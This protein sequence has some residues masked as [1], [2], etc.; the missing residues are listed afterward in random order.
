MK[1]PLN[2]MLQLLVIELRDWPEDCGEYASWDPSGGPFDFG[3]VVFTAD[4]PKVM[5][6]SIAIHGVWSLSEVPHDSKTAIVTRSQWILARQ[7]AVVKPKDEWAAQQSEKY[8]AYWRA[9]PAHWTHLDT[10]RINEL[11][12]VEDDSGAIL[13]A[14]K[15]LLLP[16]V[17]TGDKG[18]LKDV[19]EAASTLQCYINK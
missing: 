10:Y 8:P 16:G 3:A 19:Q 2:A 12:P 17:R 4:R 11:F 6:R 14:R 5:G 7:A 9:I 1:K 18:M 13:H 15:K